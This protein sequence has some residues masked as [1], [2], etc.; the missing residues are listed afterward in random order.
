MKEINQLHLSSRQRCD[1]ELLMNGAFAPLAGFMG[2][3]EA[4]SVLDSYHL[5]NGAFFPMPIVLDVFKSDNIQEGRPL[6]LCDGDG[7]ILA[8]V[9][10]TSI[11]EPNKKD[12]AEKL[13]GTT[14]ESHPG[15]YQIFR[16]MGPFFLGGKVKKRQTPPHYD[17][18]HLRHSPAD[19]QKIFA[20]QGIQK[21]VAFNTRNPI[22]RAHYELTRRAMEKMG[23]H[24]LIHP[25]VGMTKPGDIDY[26]TRVKCYQSVLKYYPRDRVFLSLLPLA[27]RMAG[28]REAL[29]HGLIRK[30]YGCTHF[31]VGR[32]HASP[33][34][35]ARGKPFY[36]PYDA[37][38]LF[39][40][41]EKEIGIKM[42]PSQ[43]IVYS[44]SRKK[45]ILAD[46]IKGGEEKTD[47][48]SG[49]R[50]RNALEKRQPLPDWFSFPEV[51]VH[52]QNSI[53]PRSERGLTVFFTGLSGSGKSTV[54]N[55]LAGLLREKSSRTVTLLDGD[56]VRQNLSKGL[57]FSKEDRDINVRRIGFV[58]AEI[59][60]HGGICLCCPIAPY[61][62][63]RRENRARI[64][65]LGG[66]YVE[67]YMAAPLSV[68]EARD[69]KGLYA[70]AR[71]GLQKQ[72][73]GVDDPYEPPED[74]ELVIN[75]S[76]GT[77]LEAAKRIWDYLLEKGYM[78]H[79]NS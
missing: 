9:E 22:H 69:P 12:F 59:S 55:F 45:Y 37:Q 74:A 76:T 78:A 65:G 67:V 68:C 66:H 41:Y 18:L 36:G 75:T 19:L 2:S 43:E 15:V 16:E 46:E 26:V 10:V 4:A 17:F 72:V 50:L 28:P 60:K 48:I 25:V 5:P 54:A 1:L 73:T 7:T 64:A 35:N 31:I 77:P 42:I 21:C 29:W 33:G 56:L 8:S 58:A 30:N 13:F 38:A 27:M 40:K 34:L 47:S 32:D 6:W 53:R 61:A 71:K 62:A 20:E 70:R 51:M 57:G 3:K 24:L 63:V 11:W 79:E 39:S 14:D 49:T 52:L 44:H 23:G